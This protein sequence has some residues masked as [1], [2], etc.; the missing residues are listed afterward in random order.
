MYGFENGIYSD[1][2]VTYDANK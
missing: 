2:H 1:Y